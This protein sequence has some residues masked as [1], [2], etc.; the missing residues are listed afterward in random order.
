MTQAIA[1]AVILGVVG[2]LTGAWLL[3]RYDQGRPTQS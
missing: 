3:Q 2:G 1:L